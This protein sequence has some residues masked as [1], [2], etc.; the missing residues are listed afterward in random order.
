VEPPNLLR[1]SS[2]ALR[3]TIGVI[4]VEAAVVAHI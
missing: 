2:A 3:Y 1:A 4:D